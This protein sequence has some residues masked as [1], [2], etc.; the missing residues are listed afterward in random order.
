MKTIATYSFLPWLRQGIANTIKSA[1][2]DTTVKARAAIDV[3]LTLSGDPV[4]GGAELT[5]AIAQKVA[6]YG[7]GDITRIEQRAVV[8]TE[9]Q[10][11]IANFESNYLPA[12]DFYD[13]DFPWRYTPAAPDSSGLR[14]RPWIALIVLAENEFTEDNQPAGQPLP[15]I[16]VTDLS[17]FPA[18][19]DLWAWA[20][21]HFNQSLS[22]DPHNLVSPD[23]SAVLPRVQSILA[24]NPDHAY[25]RLMCPRR[26][27]DSTGYHA[28]VVP[29]FETGRLAGLFEHP[30]AAPHATFSAW[31]TY[32]GKPAATSFPVF[33]RWS[34]RTASHGD[35]EY[36]V[37]LL[38]PRPVDKKVGTRDM[39]VQDPG[40]N[41]PGILDAPL[42]G[43]LK[44]GGALRV[45]DADLN[46]AELAERNKY[47][48]W[49]QP[50]PHKFETALA[51]FV[52]LPDDY[53]SQTPQAA[54]AGSGLGPGVD[55]DPDPLITAP[56]YGRW[57]S[58][59]QRLLL[60][61]DATPAPNNTNWVHRLNLDPRFRVA[62]NFG[63][64]VVETNA[65]EYMNKA[66]QQI[67]DVLA[68]NARIRR[69]HL[70]RE[71]SWRWHEGEVKALSA[72]NTERAFTLL[73]PV[74]SRIMASP[75]TI[76]YLQGGSMVPPVYTSALMRRVLRPGSRM[77]RTLPFTAALTPGNLLTRVNNGE[78][79]PAPP[80]VVAPGVTTVDQVSGAA[81]PP[82]VPSWL[83][84]LLLRYPWL[85]KAVLV[86]AILLALL[87]LFTI[88]IAGIF[89]G[90]A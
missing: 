89:L 1:D 9:P 19:A 2:G 84:D 11:W 34:F 29:V 82:N 27:A 79:S 43:V 57:H 44:L 59:T 50:Y 75:T 35:F 23:M 10:P 5:Q 54:N 31:D 63:T 17:V 20:H 40:S 32:G 28:F 49:D 42:A 80:V 85:P 25:S 51:K 68:A 71:I 65:E 66:W 26:L 14:L 22:A 60:N 64:D 83:L 81:T 87:F 52:N 78:V 15:S 69:L 72:A 12:I 41:I 70:A 16:K 46:P 76:A 24:A 13:E 90:A 38:K 37:R 33:Y 18:A 74:A 53:A 6:L 77:M 21:V 58:L 45:P 88:P 3:V 8:R 4:G 48:N 30:P 61:R 39:D 86:I 7:P 36:L 73:A 67:G 62:A 55:D 56:L 47:E